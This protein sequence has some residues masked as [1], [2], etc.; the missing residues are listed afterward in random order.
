MKLLNK[1]KV[2]HPKIDKPFKTITNRTAYFNFLLYLTGLHGPVV[3]IAD[4]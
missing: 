4:S 1:N 3:R 2:K